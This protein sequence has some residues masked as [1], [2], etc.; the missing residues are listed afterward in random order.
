MDSKPKR[1]VPPHVW[2]DYLQALADR[3][4][5]A[6]AKQWKILIS[7]A[8]VKFRLHGGSKC[9]ICKAPVRHRIPVLIQRKTG[10]IEEYA[11]LCTRCVE[12]ERAQSRR[13]MVR[14]GDA[15]LEEMRHEPRYPAKVL[16][17]RAT[18]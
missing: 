14:L 3:D 6:E 9:A 16:K 15:V 11:C 5:S 13:V 12:G 1:T 8:E 10:T 7:Y 4:S 2:Q 18:G 17:K